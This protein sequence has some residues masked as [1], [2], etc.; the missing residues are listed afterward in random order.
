M[1]YETIVLVSSVASESGGLV[2]SP[3]LVVVVDSLGA[4]AVLAAVVVVVL[5]LVA[6]LTVV[7]VVEIVV[8][9]VGNVVVCSIGFIVEVG[10]ALP[11]NNASL[12]DLE[13][14]EACCR[15]KFESCRPCS[16]EEFISI[17]VISSLDLANLD[18]CSENI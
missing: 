14:L 3:L 9:V 8:V 13:S 5:V 18:L 4:L 1:G 7:E 16:L 6:L 17:E 15:E 12:P 10:S 2:C 11:A